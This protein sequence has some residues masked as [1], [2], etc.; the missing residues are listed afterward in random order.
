MTAYT[1][2]EVR[3]VVSLTRP[4]TA[5]QATWHVEG[6]RPRYVVTSAA[7]WLCEPETYVYPCDEHGTITAW[8]EQPG[9]FKGALDHN[10]AIEGY[11]AALNG[12]DA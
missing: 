2:T 5:Y 12:G 7:V 1:A 10:R 6:P 3:R 9:S 11:L 8:D 4:G